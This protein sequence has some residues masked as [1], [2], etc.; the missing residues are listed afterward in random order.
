[1][2]VSQI[3]FSFFANNYFHRIADKSV[4]HLTSTGIM[5]WMIDNE[6][7]FKYKFILKNYPKKLTFENLSFGF[8]IWL[9]CCGISILVFA[10]EIICSKLKKK[11]GQTSRYKLRMRSKKLRILKKQIRIKKAYKMKRRLKIKNKVLKVRKIA[12]KF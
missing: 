4:Q 10:C 1:M 3:G 7:G 6:I 5:F 2:Q 12:F 11:I 8:V 9:G